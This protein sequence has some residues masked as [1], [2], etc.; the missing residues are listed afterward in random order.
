MDN[1]HCIAVEDMALFGESSFGQGLRFFRSI[2]SGQILGVNFSVWAQIFGISFF[3]E[4]IYLRQVS[5]LHW[6]IY[7]FRH[8]VLLQARM[9]YVR[10]LNHKFYIISVKMM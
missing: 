1:F 10:V 9:S 7:V 3:Y 2:L 5:I 6:L 4:V 8:F